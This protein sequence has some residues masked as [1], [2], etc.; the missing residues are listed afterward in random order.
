LNQL[1]VILGKDPVS[2]SAEKMKKWESL[3][4]QL[5]ECGTSGILVG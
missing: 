3:G 5:A 1:E 4:M 2:I